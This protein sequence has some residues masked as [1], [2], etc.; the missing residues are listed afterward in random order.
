MSLLD[1]PNSTRILLDAW[2]EKLAQVLESMTDQRP[3]S[4]WRTATGTAADLGIGSATE[5]LWWRVKL[6]VCP[7]AEIWIAAPKTT[8]EQAGS[9]TLRAA[10]LESSNPEEIK[11]TWFEILAQWD[12]ALARSLAAHLGREVT[13]EPGSQSSTDGRH[14][15]LLA[16]LRFADTELPPVAV[17]FS[18]SLVAL[19]TAP[20]SSTETSESR[21]ENE[22]QGSGHSQDLAVP[23]RTLDLLMDVDLPVSIS[24]GK[25]QLPL[26]D[27]LKLT[28][29]SIV[30]LNRNINEPVEVLVNHCLIARGEVVVVDGNY[31]IRIQQIASRQDRLRS[32]P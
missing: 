5:T 10:G 17:A 1:C 22:R 30:E 31:G 26:K 11:S 4:S 16:S 19:V 21:A 8:W 18:S 9:L 24:F 23:T 7:E 6:R 20:A 32:L 15:W 3:V 27:V 13:C 28:T 12:S 29:G 2:V 14:E 25:T